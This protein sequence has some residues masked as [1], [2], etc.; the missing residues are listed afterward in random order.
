[1]QYSI[2]NDNIIKT[3]SF[4]TKNLMKSSH[5]P[6]TIRST[7]NCFKKYFIGE[8]TKRIKPQFDNIITTDSIDI[9]K[10]KTFNNFRY[11]TENHKIRVKKYNPKS[12]N[13]P[14]LF[15]NKTERKKYSEKTY[16]KNIK[17]VKNKLKNKFNLCCKELNFPYTKPKLNNPNIINYNNFS[18]KNNDNFDKIQNNIRKRLFLKSFAK[19]H[20]LINKS[21]NDKK[22]NEKI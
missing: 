14:F 4:L 12:I 16:K 15:N 2:Y 1:M 7:P 5:F 13:F 20:L 3:K 22:V 11:N 18:I 6:S 19:L 17:L 8:L 9:K 10:N 21:Q